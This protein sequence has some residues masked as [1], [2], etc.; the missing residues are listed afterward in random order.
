MNMLHKI[1]LLAEVNDEF[2]LGKLIKELNSQTFYEITS[3][4][5]WLLEKANELKER[6]KTPS[7][8]A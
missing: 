7:H 1:T 2:K 8:T 4:K 6:S 3:H 5:T